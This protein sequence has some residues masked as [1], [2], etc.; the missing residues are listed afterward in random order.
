MTA[1]AVLTA[2]S[3]PIAWL[4]NKVIFLLRQDA[5]HEALVDDVKEIK[6]DVR[7]IWDSIRRP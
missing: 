1:A 4:F 2:L 7:R 6:T 5:K 3:P